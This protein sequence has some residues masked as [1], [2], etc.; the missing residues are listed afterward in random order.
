M[1]RIVLAQTSAIFGLAIASMVVVLNY[2]VKTISPTA[3][4]IVALV[5]FAAVVAAAMLIAWAGEAS[6]FSVSQ[7]LALAVVALVQT[8]PEFFVEGGIAWL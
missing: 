7:G 1:R 3:L 6:Q 4:G 5:T 2:D 8:L